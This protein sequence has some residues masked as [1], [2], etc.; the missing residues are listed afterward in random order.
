MLCILLALGFFAALIFSVAVPITLAMRPHSL[1][2]P[3]HPDPATPSTSGLNINPLN[4]SYSVTAVGAAPYR[5]AVMGSDSSVD[6]LWR[7]SGEEHAAADAVADFGGDSQGGFMQQLT[8]KRSVYGANVLHACMM[9]PFLHNMLNPG[10]T[11]LHAQAGTL[12]L[13]IVRL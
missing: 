3:L 5:E 10:Q 12:H 8:C 7:A 2:S 9:W 11:C 13:C 1:N 4:G 6:D